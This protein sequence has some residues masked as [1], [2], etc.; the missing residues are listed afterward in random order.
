MAQKAN[1]A[2]MLRA[3]VNANRGNKDAVS[4]KD[5]GEYV[6]VRYDTSDALRM[7]RLDERLETRLRDAIDKNFAD[8]VIGFKP[9]FHN[10]CTA[11]YE[12]VFDGET[13]KKWDEGSAEYRRGAFAYYANK[14]PGEYC[15]D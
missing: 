13:Q 6:W 2:E 15:G 8:R 5:G 1:L 14:R 3:A 12:P 11:S 4:G 7:M 10:G 9:N